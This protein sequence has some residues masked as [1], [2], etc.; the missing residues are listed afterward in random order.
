MGSDE[1]N[2]M[3]AEIGLGVEKAESEHKDKEGFSATWDKLAEQ[4]KEIKDKGGE[5][6]SPPE[7]P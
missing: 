4:I 5:P 3:I 2:D 7:W 1:M 6:I